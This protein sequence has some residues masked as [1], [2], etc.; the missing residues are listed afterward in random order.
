MVGNRRPGLVVMPA[1][2]PAVTPQAQM[3]E[4]FVADHDAL[5]PQQFVQGERR[6]PG[7]A[8]RPSPAL[9]TILRRR[10]AF[11]DVAGF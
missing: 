11:D 7:L 8:N 6:A 2:E 3:H 5:Q 4:T 9:N 1:D 10:F